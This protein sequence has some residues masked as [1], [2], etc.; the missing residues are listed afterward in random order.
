VTGLPP[1]L[2]MMMALGVFWLVSLGE[3][4]ETI[5]C[6]EVDRSTRGGFL[7]T[8]TLQHYHQQQQHHRRR[9]RHHHHHHHHHQHHHHSN[10]D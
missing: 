7:A 9:R 2:G 10:D 6:G 4:D 1:Y 8:S 5:F 3:N